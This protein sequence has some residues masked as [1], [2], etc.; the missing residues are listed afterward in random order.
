MTTTE[1][2]YVS[3]VTSAIQTQFSGKQATITGAASSVT[4]ND[5]STYRIVITDGNGK[6]VASTTEAFNVD[7]ETEIN[8][9][10]GDTDSIGEDIDFTQPLQDMALPQKTIT[11]E[12]S[13]SKTFVTGTNGSRIYVIQ[14]VGSTPSAGTVSITIGGEQVEIMEGDNPLV[15]KYKN[16]VNNTDMPG[17]TVERG[18]E[19]PFYVVGGGVTV[20]LESSSSNCDV[21]V[22]YVDLE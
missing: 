7:S 9:G 1:L 11:Q 10:I 22:T 13:G 20:T 2:G 12:G 18:T 19:Q 3:G 6:L 21:I 17:I 15:K 16:Y 14:F 4:T 8:P 5:L